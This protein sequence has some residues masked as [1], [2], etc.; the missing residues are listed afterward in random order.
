MLSS[1]LDRIF[2]ARRST[3]R[4]P[5]RAARPIDRRRMF[6]E[7]LENRALLAT[8]VGDFTTFTQGGWGAGPNGN[9]P[10]TYLH[11]GA[12]DGANFAAAFPGGLQIGSQVAG[13]ASDADTS[14][15]NQAALFTSAQALTDWLPHGGPSGPLGG[16]TV[17]PS[18][19]SAPDDGTLAGQ[20]AALALAVGFDLYDPSFSASTTHLKDLTVA[21]S[22]SPFFGKTV[23]YVL[24]TSNAILS[25]LTT[26]GYT[27][28]QA[29]VAATAINENFDNGIVNN[30]FLKGY[31]DHCHQDA[32]S[33]VTIAGLKFEDHN[34]NG[35]Q[36]AGDGGIKDWHFTI[37]VDTNGNGVEED[38][39]FVDALNG[40]YNPGEAFTDSIIPLNGVYDAGEAFVDA[41]NGKYDLGETFTDAGSLNGVYDDEVHDVVTVAGGGFSYSQVVSSTVLAGGIKYEIQEVS[42]LDYVPTKGEDG[43]SGTFTTANPNVA[44]VYNAGNYVNGPLF[45]NTHIGAE[46]GKTIGFWSNKNGQALITAADID[47]LKA[48]NL[49]NA[50]GIDADFDP[51]PLTA[52]SLAELSAAKSALKSFLLGANATNM[53]NMLSAQLAGTVLNVNHAMFGSS[54]TIYIDGLL[55][56]WSGNSQ[57]TNLATNLD[58]DLDTDNADADG[59]V[60]AYGFA[61]I[62]GLITAANTELGSSSLVLGGHAERAYEEALKIAFDGMN[63]NLA[64]FA[65]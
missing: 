22:A 44:I 50:N 18:V 54:T 46:L 10:G 27:A 20:T 37:W 31:V 61:S 53:A 32:P 63:N 30:G 7:T 48:L 25:G 49:R 58:H 56:T 4:S 5:K 9:N 16:D 8:C 52:C 40:V 57:G 39:V 62:A 6:L 21:D 29:N 26:T 23:Q 65:L 59:N 12:T 11:A 41:L 36:D 38:E 13:A 47:S 3:R 34:G 15:G 43:Y 55:T 1:I 17:N 24:D 64:I 33:L 42:Q 14:A 2:P 35:V 60:N 19:P 51:T 28:D 45:G